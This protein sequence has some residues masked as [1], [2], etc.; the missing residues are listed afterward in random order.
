MEEHKEME[1][2]KDLD[3]ICSLLTK[4]VTIHEF[5]TGNKQ[6][7]KTIYDAL[8]FCKENIKKNGY[9]YVEINYQDLNGN[10]HVIEPKIKTNDIKSINYWKTRDLEKKLCDVSDEYNNAKEG[11]LFFV[12]RINNTNILQTNNIISKIIHSDNIK[13]KYYIKDEYKL[14]FNSSIFKN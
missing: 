12:E 2:K 11:D 8:E 3:Y 10:K 9:K 4:N 6:H 7:F 13:E 1:I 5:Q 14:A